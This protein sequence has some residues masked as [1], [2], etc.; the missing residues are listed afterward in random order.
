M[1][2]LDN[3]RKLVVVSNSHYLYVRFLCKIELQRTNRRFY[4]LEISKLLGAYGTD[5]EDRQ[6]A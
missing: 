2:A 6:Y 5:R 1:A 4:K 3:L